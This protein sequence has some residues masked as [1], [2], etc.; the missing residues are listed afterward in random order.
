MTSSRLK[1][2]FSNG[3]YSIANGFATPVTHFLNY[4]TTID[5]N[6]L[7]ISHLILSNH[8]E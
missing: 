6:N 5:D 2:F 1:Q 3:F 7:T 4:E 8:T